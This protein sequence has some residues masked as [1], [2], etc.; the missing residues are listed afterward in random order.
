MTKRRDYA[1]HALETLGSGLPDTRS[2]QE[3]ITTYLSAVA[4]ACYL[5]NMSHYCRHRPIRHSCR[6]T[7]IARVDMVGRKSASRTSASTRRPYLCSRQSGQGLGT[8]SAP[9]RPCSKPNGPRRRSSMS[10]HG[11]NKN[12]CY[13]SQNYTIRQ[14][15][16]PSTSTL[17]QPYRTLLRHP[18]TRLTP[19]SVI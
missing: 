19:S 1:Q 4:M 12:V 3:P 11:A 14:L 17:E 15:T 6:T 2:G 7:H 9:L 18:L 5:R 8:R 10:S 13:W 16:P